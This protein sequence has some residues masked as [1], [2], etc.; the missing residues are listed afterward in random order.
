M[1]SC[2]LPVEVVDLIIDQLCVDFLALK[3]CSFVCRAWTPSSRAHL[4]R[5]LELRPAGRASPENWHRFLSSSPHIIS[6]IQ[7]LSIFCERSSW[8]S[9]D[10]VLPNLLAKFQNIHQIDLYGCD[11][12]WLPA[13]LTSAIYTLF[14]SPSMK[15]VSLRLCVLPSS[16]FEL[17]GSALESI[18]L[19]DV[20]IEPDST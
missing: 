7:E 1:E 6:H 13:P 4:F 10:P 15:R 3:S 11:L 9:W 18:E 20:A 19:S 16:C 12:P 5:Y 14:R 8:V 2:P 17:F